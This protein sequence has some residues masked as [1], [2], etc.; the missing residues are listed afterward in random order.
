MRGD[1]N[2]TLLKE[3]P[4]EV[5]ARHDRAIKYDRSQN[6][7]RDPRGIAASPLGAVLDLLAGEAA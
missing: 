1:I 6:K 3:G 5:R 2:D 7:L 4:D